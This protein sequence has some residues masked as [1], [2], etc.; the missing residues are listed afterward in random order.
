MNSWEIWDLIYSI[1][2]Y[3]HAAAIPIGLIGNFISLLIFTR[4]NLNKKTN[5]GFLYSILCAL[6]IIKL[7][8][9]GF[10]SQPLIFLNYTIRL[11]CYLNPFITTSLIYSLSWMQVLISF[12][13]FLLVI[14]PFK[15]KFMAKK[16]DFVILILI[17]HKYTN[18]LYA[19]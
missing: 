17:Y 7:V 11:H 8:E 12:D 2:K 15:S 4:P 16:V 10:I 13:R 5:A 19:F 18:Y 1:R 9:L 6:N 14:F 3:F